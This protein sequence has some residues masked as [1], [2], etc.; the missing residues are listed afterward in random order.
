MPRSPKMEPINTGKKTNAGRIVWKNPKSGE[1][2]S[3]KSATIPLKIDYKTGEPK[4]GTPWV[5]VPTVFEGGKILDDEDF[6]RK[7]Y[8]QNGYKDPL[9]GKKLDVFDSLDDALEQ[10]KKRSEGLLP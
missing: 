6:L 7:F 1:V 2:Y 3:E 5:N 8:S 4:A 10:A 9:T